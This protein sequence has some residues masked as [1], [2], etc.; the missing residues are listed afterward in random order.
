MLFFSDPSNRAV[1]S[2]GVQDM[3]LS[4]GARISLIAIVDSVASHK[5]KP[6]IL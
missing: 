1:R 5:R 2:D 6:F 3:S 4:N